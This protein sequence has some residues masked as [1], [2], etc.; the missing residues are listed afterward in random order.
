ALFASFHTH[1]HA[2]AL[3]IVPML[4]ALRTRRDQ[5]PLLNLLSLLIFLPTFSV[6]S[7]G[8]LEH[9]AWIL[10][11]LMIITFGVILVEPRRPPRG[12]IPRVARPSPMARSAARAYNGRV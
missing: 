4:A 6:A 7:D 12:A 2:A 11:A 1:I 10:M 9:C 8:I 3:L 5:D